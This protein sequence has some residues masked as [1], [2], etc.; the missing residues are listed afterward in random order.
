MKRAVFSWRRLRIALLAAILAFVGA[1]HYWEQ[2]EVRSWRQPL[3]IAIYP[4]NGDG[5]AAASGYIAA[6]APGQFQEI[7]DFVQTQASRYGVKAALPQ[8]LLRPEI[9]DLPQ[10]PPEDKSNKFAVILWSLKLRYWVYQHGASWLPSFG[11]IRLFVVYHVGQPGVALAHSLGLREGLIG[12]VHAFAKPVQDSQNNVVIAHELLHTLGATDKYG[13][14]GLPL[15]P[16]GYGD[17]ERVPRHPQQVAEIMAG[18]VAVSETRAD[19]P[20]D[21][22]A[23]AIG[24]KTAHEINW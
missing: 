12:V 22:A 6:L 9:K 3:T 15:F 18:R 13:P 19:I 5:S 23:C 1:T 14:G 7:A 8:L 17:A 16:E 20:A 24:Y 21:L 2:R 11:V 10:A 4:V